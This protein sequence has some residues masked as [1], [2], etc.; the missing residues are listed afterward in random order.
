M[1]VIQTALCGSALSSTHIL[2]PVHMLMAIF[3]PFWISQQQHP[4]FMSLPSQTPSKR[5]ERSHQN[6]KLRPRAIAALQSAVQTSIS[7]ESST[8]TPC[9]SHAS[10][11]KALNLSS[12]NVACDSVSSETITEPQYSSPAAQTLSTPSQSR[13]GTIPTPSSHNQLE[14]V[15]APTQSTCIANMGPTLQ[16]PNQSKAGV[17]HALLIPNQ[18]GSS[19]APT[20]KQSRPS[21]PSTLSTHSKSDSCG[22]SSVGMNLHPSISISQVNT[23][24]ATPFNNNMPTS[25]LI[26]SPSISISQVNQQLP[27]SSPQQAI[28]SDSSVP[29]SNPGLASPLATNA[30]MTLI[31]QVLSN[32][33]TPTQSTSRAASLIDPNY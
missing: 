28:H 5:L 27:T 24:S 7:G 20:S 31:S 33:A 2:F 3:K 10:Q 26:Q 21:T 25:S 1:L 22:T 15:T 29:N 8:S 30:L 12:L 23:P 17:G 32:C 4:I 9:Q 14:S 6:E 18:S 16:S 13:L 11:P 19:T